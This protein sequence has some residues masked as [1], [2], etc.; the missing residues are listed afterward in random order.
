MSTTGI[1]QQSQADGFEPLRPYRPESYAELEARLITAN[2]RAARLE[3]QLAAVTA[4]RDTAEHR[5]AELEAINRELASDLDTALDLAS[6]NA[7]SA[8]RE[9]LVPKP[10][11][12]HAFAGLVRGTERGGMQ[13]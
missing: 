5:A 4:E 10:I 11:Y 12:G 13:R 9:R 6:E 7:L 8:G 2:E 1:R 3:E